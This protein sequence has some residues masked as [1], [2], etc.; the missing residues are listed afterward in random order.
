MALRL[1]R[2]LPWFLAV[3]A[4]ARIAGDGRVSIA[5]AQ[6]PPPSPPPTVNGHVSG[7]GSTPPTGLNFRFPPINSE[8]DPNYSPHPTVFNISPATIPTAYPLGID[9]VPK[10]ISPNFSGTTVRSDQPTRFEAWATTPGK[11]TNLQGNPNGI[12]TTNPYFTPDQMIT[13]AGASCNQPIDMT[14]HAKWGTVKGKVTLKDN[15]PLPFTFVVEARPKLPYPSPAPDNRWTT[16]ETSTNDEGEYIFKK[17][18]LSSE[19]PGNLCHP[20]FTNICRPI[21]IPAENDW[22]LPVLGDGG[23]D[24]RD[25]HYFS[26][27]PGKYEWDVALSP[28]HTKRIEVTSSRASEVEFKLD[29]QDYFDT[30]IYQIENRPFKDDGPEGKRNPQCG[31]EDG[32]SLIGGGPGAAPYPVSLITGNVFLDQEDISLPGVRHD[33]VFER[34]YNSVGSGSSRFGWGWSDAF[35]KRVEF[36]S[37]RAIR[38]WTGGGTPSYFTDPDGDGILR[39]YGAPNASNW[40]TATATGFRRTFRAGG[41][42]EYDSAGRFRKQV[43]RTGRATTLNY[44]GNRLTEIVSPEGRQLRLEYG[45]VPGRVSRL[46]GPMGLIAEYRYA[47]N[48][49]FFG[50]DYELRQVKYAD[51]T[52]YTFAYDSA[53][54]ILTASDLAGVILHSHGYDS[55][56]RAAWSAMSGGQE[57]RDFTYEDGRT[58]VRDARGAVS[59]FEFTQKMAGRFIT[60]VTGCGFCGNASGTRSWD[61]DDQGRVTRYVDANSKVTLYGWQGDNLVSVVD[62]L[63]RETTLSDFDEFGRPRSITIPGHGTTT[64]T[65]SPEG[66]QSVTLPTGVTSSATYENQRLKAVSTAGLSLAV[67]VNELGDVLS[68]ADT[69]GKVTTFTYDPMGRIVSST[70]PDHQTTRYER[71]TGGRMSAVVRPDGT[72]ASV[73]YDGSGRIA[74]FTDE[75]HRTFAIAYDAHSRLKALSGPL[76]S[77]QFEYDAMSN[78]RALTD[79]L[80]RTTTFDYDLHGRIESITDP[81]SAAESYTYY[82]DGLIHTHTDRRGTTRTFGYD[83]N[84]RITSLSYSDGTPALSVAYHDAESSAT[85]SNG[86]D[87]VTRN[88][89][90]AGRLLTETSALNASTVAYTYTSH[91]APETLSL[92][93]DLIANYSYTEG[94]LSSIGFDG[95]QIGLAHD[96]RGRRTALTFPNGLETTYDYDNPTGLLTRIRL[97][98][99]ATSVWEVSYTHDNLGRQLTRSSAGQTQQYSFDFGSRLTAV[100]RAA[101]TPKTWSWTFDAVGNRTEERIDGVPRSMSYDI[102]DRLVNAQGGGLVR[103]EGH[104]SEA[105]TVTVDGHPARLLPGN[106]FQA[107][108]PR[109]AGQ[110]TFVI[111]ARDASGNVRT[112]TYQVE[113]GTDGTTY[114]Y[115]ANGSVTSMVDS[116]GTTTYVWNGARQLTRVLRDG[117]EIASFAYDP[118]G[119]RVRKVMGGVTYSYTY[120]GEDILRETRSDGTSFTYIHGPGVDEPLARRTAGGSTSYLH[121]DVLGSI[122]RVTDA[123]GSVT[124]SREYDAWGGI[125]TGA[126]K[127]GYAFTGREWDPETALYYF[128]ARYY[129]P[130][131][132]RFISADPLALEHGSSRYGYASGDP[133][134]SVDPS[135]LADYQPRFPASGRIPGTKITYRM[136]F[137]QSGLPNMHIYWPDGKETI[138]SNLGRWLEKHGG[139]DLVTPPM[140]YRSALRPIA[141]D[142]VKRCAKQLSAGA[143]KALAMFGDPIALAEGYEADMDRALRAVEK[144]I[145]YEQQLLEDARENGYIQT[146]VG[147]LPR[148][149]FE[150]V[151]GHQES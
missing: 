19:D 86:T 64:L 148:E 96:D 57:R 54:R 71:T 114:S 74:S 92:N 23:V 46:L 135:G 138:I 130:K 129:D 27:E 112:S 22:A 126:D 20:P 28:K 25:G 143:G 90:A 149:F 17:G 24:G 30:L 94:V 38:L 33:L 72:R 136:D 137:R 131:V 65:Y 98:A 106:V 103:V 147:I 93:G 41:Y 84:G 87:T 49:P 85:F 111:E 40:I 144:G 32:D 13:C 66:L 82:S 69:R 43:D 127:P 77:T 104:T 146:P 115:D 61:L 58:L 151:Y 44:S 7:D 63:D 118:L 14:F 134:S 6:D 132:G 76:G 124:E 45:S 52:G 75:A 141:K 39:Q 59:T 70:T 120:D 8:P 18:S 80:H 47:Y 12:W 83:N 145:T 55:Q 95:Q 79:P 81:A 16:Y 53:H 9:E 1:R 110:T 105:S 29:I 150:I 78:L 3:V 26:N 100:N 15:V 88:Y 21:P 62:T 56:G 99:G 142:F 34:S 119:R 91:Q 4:I 122:V 48:G 67:D 133:V 37:A 11:R 50:G 2:L 42:E 140:K 97:A 125:E 139:R 102:R 107:D 68:I 123:S 73:S 5:K 101:T 35:D 60:R 51:G 89:N 113:V 116:G 121:A 10:D 36:F 108:V 117:A 109:A 128:R 31:G